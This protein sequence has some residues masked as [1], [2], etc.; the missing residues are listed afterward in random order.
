[1][2]VVL[3]YTLSIQPELSHSLYFVDKELVFVKNML[4]PKCYFEA[5]GFSLMALVN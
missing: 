2:V 4:Y 3:Q 1:M 5:I